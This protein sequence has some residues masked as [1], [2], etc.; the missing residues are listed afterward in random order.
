MEKNFAHFVD[1][2]IKISYFITQSFPQ[3][4]CG[5]LIQIVY[6]LRLVVYCFYER[7]CGSFVYDYCVDVSVDKVGNCILRGCV[8]FAFKVCKSV[9][10]PVFIADYVHAARRTVLETYF[11]ARKGRQ[12]SFYVCGRFA[13]IEIG[14]A[15]GNDKL[16]GSFVI[17]LRESVKRFSIFA[18][19]DTSHTNIRITS[20]YLSEDCVEVDVLNNEIKVFCLR[21]SCCN[22]NVYAVNFTVIADVFKGFKGTVSCNDK[23]IGCVFYVGGGYVITNFFAFAFKV[24]RYDFVEFTFRFESCEEGIEIVYERGIV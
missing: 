13:V 16:L 20:F 2:F 22:F 4:D 15:C 8:T 21:V 5:K 11:L 10:A 24:F 19:R 1:Q 17:F 3:L 14:V 6:Y 9:V 23:F 18:C 12:N 7:V